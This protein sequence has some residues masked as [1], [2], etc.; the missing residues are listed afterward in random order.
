M[1]PLYVLHSPH[2]PA[3]PPPLWS[4][5]ALRAWR[6]CPRKWALAHARY[7]NVQ[8]ET[9]P[10][11]VTMAAIEGTLVHDAIEQFR[12][13][14]RA[15]IPF[16]LR[17]FLSERFQ[18]I[19]DTEGPKNPRLDVS[20]LWAAVSFNVCADR[21]RTL[22]DGMS[23]QSPRREPLVGGTR[24]APSGP[25]RP[26]AEDEEHYLKVD[27]PPLHGIIDQVQHGR[28]IDT[29]TG[30]A[31]EWH[32]EQLRFYALLWWIKFNE[33]PAALELQ[34]ADDKGVVPVAVPTVAE[35][36]TLRDQLRE[37]IAGAKELLSQRQESAHPSAEGCRFCPVRQLCQDYWTS[38]ATLEWRTVSE[39]QR[40]ADVLVTKLPS[41]WEPGRPVA[42][43]VTIRLGQEERPATLMIDRSR[44][45]E[46]K[47]DRA[48]ILGAHVD[49]S[50]ETAVVKTVV[51]SEVFWV[52]SGSL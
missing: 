42:G 39:E 1:H 44:C 5:T 47:C 17:L 2:Q 24:Q 49:L 8:T 21:F 48:I 12:E 52:P 16:R 34:Y 30:E 50:G 26:P 6:E 46:E 18:K 13:N 35:L 29:K 19:L 45:P 3:E 27:D 36:N 23:P 37:E 20:R 4:F 38:D 32:P 33:R 40:F 22:V 25:P 9:Y 10:E 7:P 41:G 31:K 15:G 51:T 43:I 28:L 14:R 11:R